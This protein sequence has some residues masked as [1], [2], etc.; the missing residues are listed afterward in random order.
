MRNKKV[1]KIILNFD[2]TVHF[3][4]FLKSFEK[5]VI[6]EIIRSILTILSA[7]SSKDFRQK[8]KRLKNVFLNDI[9]CQNVKKLSSCCP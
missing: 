9:H 6:S 1:F 3:H 5:N 4:D 2:I 8:I 7:L